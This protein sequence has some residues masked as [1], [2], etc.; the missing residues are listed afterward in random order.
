[1][2]PESSNSKES[3]CPSVVYLSEITSTK[4]ES[5]I[6][7]L[8]FIRVVYPTVK[9]ARNRAIVLALLSCDIRKPRDT[10]VKLFQQ[11]CFN[12]LNIEQT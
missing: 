7:D 2:P 5:G 3:K 8:K 1:M 10:F 12:D 11:S 4:L 9:E 6:S